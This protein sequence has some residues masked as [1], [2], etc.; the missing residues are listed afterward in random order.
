MSMAKDSQAIFLEKRSHPQDL[1][2]N[3][4]LLKTKR[5]VNLFPKTSH[6]IMFPTRHPMFFLTHSLLFSSRLCFPKRKSEGRLTIFCCSSVG[7]ENHNKGF[8]LVGLASGKARIS[9][10]F[11][12]LGGLDLLKGTPLETS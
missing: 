2:L 9:L 5:Y 7:R 3:P 11:K 6:S 4:E 12:L 1:S 8:Y 10:L